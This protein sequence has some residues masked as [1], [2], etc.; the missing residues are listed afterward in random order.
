[1]TG[2]LQSTGNIASGQAN[3][4]ITITDPRGSIT[5]HL[6]GPTQGAFAPL[7]VSFN[8]T[9]V[10]AT[11]AF[12]GFQINGAVH[13]ALNSTNHTF[14]MNF[15]SLQMRDQN[16]LAGVG[17]GKTT[18]ALLGTAGQTDTLSGTGTVGILGA[19]GISGS[20]HNPGSGATA[21]ATGTLTLSNSDGTVTLSLTG[22]PQAGFS[23]FPGFYSYQVVRGTG[24]YSLLTGSG[25]LHLQGPYGSFTVTFDSVPTIKTGIAGI[26]MVG[27]LGP[28][29]AGQLGNMRPFA[30][31]TLL[32]EPSG[33][34]TPIARVTTDAGGQF[35]L[36]LPPGK[37]L[38]VSASYSPTHMTFPYMWPISIQVTAGSV[39][40][41]TINFYSGIA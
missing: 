35:Q 5:L 39:T 11:G 25:T 12:K 22:P 8:F 2:A 14:V 37:Y 17:S 32:V 29:Q 41:L 13:L 10:S 16:A 31:T 40:D 1:M 7:P 3:G 30:G 36:A 38:L 9:V 18:V 28:S 21:H 23:G 34:G 15:T 27:P 33:G 24:T 6:V 20:V 26:A 19:V 4:N